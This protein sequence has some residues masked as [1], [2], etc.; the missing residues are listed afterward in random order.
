MNIG[1]VEV[2]L[3]EAMASD[4]RKI[5]AGMIGA[6][7]DFI[8]DDT[9]EKCQKT[10]VWKAGNVIKDDT[11]ASGVVP[12]EVLS[13]AGTTLHVGVYGVTDGVATPTVWACLGA[14]LSGAEPSGDD[15]TDPSLPVWAQLEKRVAALEEGGGGGKETLIVNI[16]NETNPSH[17]AAFIYNYVRN[18]GNVMLEVDGVRLSLTSVAEDMATFN[19]IGDDYVGYQYTI[20]NGN[21]YS[22]DLEYASA[23]NFNV[24]SET[25]GNIETALN[26]I[27]ALQESYIG[28]V[29]K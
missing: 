3:N 18:G 11:T 6:T 7:V 13:V 29:S 24:L 4:L 26:E 22:T 15:T 21:I 12:A 16:Q 28:G 14:I 1:K 20:F 8:F 5:T 19:Y 2:R 9:W 25:V 27:T 23:E 10:I 17:D